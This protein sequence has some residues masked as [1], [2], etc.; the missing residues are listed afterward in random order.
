MT[1]NLKISELMIAKLVALG[2]S[3][4]VISP[5]S[6]STPLTVAAARH[7]QARTSVHIDERGAAYFALGNAK[8]TG[9]P[10]VLICT[11]GT[12]VANYFPAVVEASMD[13]IPIII[14]SADRPPELIDVGANQAVFQEDIYGKYPRL[15]KNLPPPEENSSIEQILNSV[16]EIYL[17]ATGIRPGPVQLNCQ[18]REPLLPSPPDQLESIKLESIKTNPLSEKR[19]PVLSSNQVTLVT[20]KIESFQQGLIIVGRSVQA[21]ANSSILD[22]AAKLKWPVMADVQSELR[23]RSHPNLI[24]H[25]DLLLLGEERSLEKPEMIIH[26]GSGFTS[27]RLL[28][29]L[30]E[31][32]V[33]YA[34]VKETPERIDPNHQVNIA[35]Q[36]DI[37]AFINSITQSLDAP[38]ETNQDQGF[39]SSVSSGHWLK[40]WQR[41]ESDV[42][43]L[44]EKH[45]SSANELNEPGIS[46]QLSKLIPTDHSLMLANSMPIR[47][48]D[49][50]AAS[51]SFVGNIIANRGASGIDGL[52]A[53]AAGYVYGSGK[54]LTMLAGDLAVLHDLNSL[55]LL[56][57]TPQPVILII[58]NNNGG[59]IFNFLP[60]A[61]ESDVFETFFGTPHGLNF[62]KAA[63]MFGLNYA[64]SDNMNAFTRTYSEVSQEQQSTII[65]VQTDR[66]ENHAFHNKLYDLIR[67]L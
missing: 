51:G 17:A 52:L 54:P 13:N 6:R 23:F 59:G 2:A 56:A 21:K 7:P 47:E 66:Y 42:S 10:T 1:Q 62:K 36:T 14:L 18:F 64:R 34:A 63:E 48:M 19:L 24:N 35:L 57:Q 5:G 31:P 12:A 9:L 58:I 22:F 26:F 29:F 40:S 37:Q 46:Y 44:L 25:G 49:M 60:I 15:F 41:A 45:I 4:F 20:R 38:G 30:K 61:G 11:S 33:Y 16:Q 53:T 8:A 28:N 39:A 50:F 55:A 65:E 43:D 32:N 3:H 27:K 67:E